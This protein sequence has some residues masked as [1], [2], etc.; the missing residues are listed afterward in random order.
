MDRRQFLRRTSL[1]AAGAVLPFQKS[2]LAHNQNNFTALRR[3]VGYYTEQGG[4]IGWLASPDATAVVD[5][6]FPETAQN[7]LNGLKD[8]S[9]HPLNLLINTHHHGDHTSGNP[10][11]ENVAEKIV[12]HQNV[13]D[14]MKK[15][16]E[17]SDDEP[18]TAYP[19]TTYSDSWQM[20]LGDEIIHTKYYG[21]GHTS[22]DSVIYFEKANVVH[23]GD[24]VFNRMNPYTDRPSGASMENW[25]QILNTVADEYPADA[26]YIFGHSNPQYE[27]TGDRDDLGVMAN[28]LSS[29]LEHVQTGIEQGK[30]KEEITDKEIL[31]GFEDFLYADFWTLSENLEVAYEEIQES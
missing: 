27:V 23:M 12:A 30:S 16:N 31:E 22:G 15:A 28:Y 25:V 13:P 4:T 19:S 18:N 3:N 17:E 7:F 2:L 11:F 21:R 26:I 20:D 5:S 8:R 29:I 24:L 9:D 10:V 1:A 14:L 6:Q